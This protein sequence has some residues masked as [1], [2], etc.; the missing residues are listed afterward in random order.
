MRFRQRAVAEAKRDGLTDEQHRAMMA[1][2][3]RRIMDFQEKWRGCRDGRCRRHRQCLG[4]P[5][6][7][8]GKGGKSPWTSGQYRRLKRDII[9]NPPKLA[10]LR[11]A[12]PRSA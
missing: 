4:P 5:F 12:A 8:H 9:R 6:A 1:E 3:D 2:F 10:A 11:L 7:C